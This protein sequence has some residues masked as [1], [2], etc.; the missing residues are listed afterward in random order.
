M[1]SATR[2]RLIAAT[3]A[4]TLLAGAGSAFAVQTSTITVGATVING[5]RTLNV[6]D[7]SGGPVSSLALGAGHGG[8]LLVN[9]SDV[10]YAHAG[11]QVTATMSNLYPYDGSYHFN[12]TPIPSSAVTMSFPGGLVD[13]AGLSTLVEPVIHLA[14]TSLPFS[15]IKPMDT[16]VT[17]AAKSV[18]TLS[19]VTQSTLNALADELPVKVSNG[20]GGA[21]TQPAAVTGQ[22]GSFNPTPVDVL[23]GSKQSLNALLNDLKNALNTG[24]AT[25]QD[26]V[27]AGVLDQNSVLAAGAA[28]LGLTSD[29][30]TSTL[31]NQIL[32]VPASVVDLQ[33][34]G[35]TLDKVLGQTGSYNTVSALSLNLP[36]QQPAG[37]YQGELTFTLL[38]K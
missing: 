8:A 29:Q 18:Q 36:D 11:Y 4:V 10:N 23:D 17:G 24:A 20:T 21:F 7:V 2:R 34:V 26:F 35:A 6:K 28:A 27:T 37:S 32:A 25:A 22:G 19:T 9:V 13:V 33:A 14:S 12:Q 16:T 15:V 1:N 31:I 3:G 38:D 5:T 30:L